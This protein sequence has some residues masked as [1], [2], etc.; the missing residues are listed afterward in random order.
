ML[1][2]A[3]GKVSFLFYFL[4]LL[5]LIV[6]QQYKMVAGQWYKVTCSFLLI[7]VLP[8]Y[9]CCKFWQSTASSALGFF[10]FLP[11]SCHG[12][13]AGSSPVPEDADVSLQQG[14]QGEQLGLLGSPLGTSR[15]PDFDDC[16]CLFLCFFFL[17]II[18]YFL[19]LS[20][21][22]KMQKVAGGVFWLSALGT[23]LKR[24][25]LHSWASSF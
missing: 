11:A 14:T 7:I 13:Q 18:F 5:G 21:K 4:F 17:I 23:V 22:G 10:C 24:A 8:R 3:A 1:Q 12:N 19:F 25:M 16:G 2:S 9:F 20:G 6:S 15:K